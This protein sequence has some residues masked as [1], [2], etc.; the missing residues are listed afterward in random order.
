METQ[1]KILKWSLIIGIIIVLNLF[2]N[3]TVSLFYKIPDY[4]VYFERPQVVE[5]VTNKEDCLKIGGQWHE[6][7]SRYDQSG[8]P[9]P[10]VA[11]EGKTKPLPAFGSCNPDYIKQQEFNNAQKIYQ[12]NVFIILV[13]LG[14]ISLVVGAFM[15]N[16]IVSIGLSWGGVLSLIIASMRYWSDADNWVKVL[17]L[18]IAL[19]ALF[20]VA[21]KKFSK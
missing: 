1:S 10:P 17:I 8:V 3:Y 12:R 14:V 7:D 21:I 5:P 13:A 16:A 6:G 9:I 15:A 2:F 20:W 11:V 18:A 19:V 4:N